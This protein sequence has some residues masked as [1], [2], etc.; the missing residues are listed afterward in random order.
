MTII[1]GCRGESRL[2]MEIGEQLFFLEVADTEALRR[3]GLM[4]RKELAP[5]SGMIFVFDRDEILGFWMKDTGIPLTIA[6]IDASGTVVDILPL[7]PY[8]RDPVFSS[9][10][11][12]YA[13]ELNRNA[14]EKAGVQEGDRLDL[15]PLFR[16]LESNR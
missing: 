2:E 7:A 15:T 3:E 11:V 14:F 13:I 4:H 8:S 6:Y 10:S 9:R 1:F 12:R 5:D 16:W